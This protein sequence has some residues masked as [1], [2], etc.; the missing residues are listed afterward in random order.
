M[1]LITISFYNRFRLIARSLA[2]FICV[3]MPVDASHTTQLRLTP[4]AP[5]HI[6]EHSKFG[7]VPTKQAEQTYA[8]LESLLSNKQYAKLKEHVHGAFLFMNDCKK[9]LMNLMDLFIHLVASLYT[10]YRSL[11]LLRIEIT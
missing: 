10:E 2:A 8:S 3:Q 11:D 4:N 5:G 9:T 7:I 1:H 6:K